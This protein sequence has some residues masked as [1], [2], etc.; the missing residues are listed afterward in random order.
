MVLFLTVSSGRGAAAGAAGNS[1]SFAYVHHEVV[2]A[3]RI[4]DSEPYDFL[5]DTDTSPSAIDRRLARRFHLRPSGSQGAASGLGSSKMTVVPVVIPRMSVGS[6]R[7]TNTAALTGDLSA[8]SAHFGRP[9][10]GVLG[11]S[12][13]RGN[14]VAFDYRCKTVTFLADAPLAPFTSR[15]RETDEDEN[16][17][18]TIAVNGRRASATFDTGNGGP[19]IVTAKGIAELNLSAQA[20]SGAAAVGYGYNGGARAN[21]GHLSDVRVGTVDLGPQAARY[22]RSADDPVD[23]NIGNESMQNFTVVFDYQRHFVTLVPARSGSAC[24]APR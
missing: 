10:Y 17:V 22:V 24:P 14:V 11:T 9:I 19:L 7:F 6:K 13:L 8:L 4:G 18:A 1:I 20:S 21:A 3:V 12:V 15:F 16:I 2:V 5:L 23:I